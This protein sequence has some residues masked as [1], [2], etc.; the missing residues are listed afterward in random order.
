MIRY[1]AN[2]GYQDRRRQRAAQIKAELLAILQENERTGE[3][4]NIPDLAIRFGC[5]ASTL[6]GMRHDLA[7][8]GLVQDPEAKRLEQL[9][10]IPLPELA[11][12]VAIVREAKFG[13]WERTGEKRL[14]KAELEQVLPI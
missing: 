10:E 7:K 3:P 13:K 6:R 5:G 1:P 4:I 11:E 2:T 9:T 14:T 8:S 12:R